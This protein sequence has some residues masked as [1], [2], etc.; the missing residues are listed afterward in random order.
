MSGA[1]EA[2][3]TAIKQRMVDNA[4]LLPV[5]RIAFPNQAFDAPDNVMYGKMEVAFRDR[6]T[7]EVGS[8]LQ[9]VQGAMVLEVV[10][11]LNVSTEAHDS[12]CAEVL[13]FYNDVDVGALRFLV[14]RVETTG[15][16]AGRYRSRV[17][18]PFHYYVE[19]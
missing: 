19:V 13:G 10:S 17:V 2:V 16:A 5:S 11:P 8:Q 12:A 3:T 18:C 1:Y 4:N 9:S 14:G 6:K 15:A 7:E